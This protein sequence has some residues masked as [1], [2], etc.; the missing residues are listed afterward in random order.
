MSS[1]VEMSSKSM[2]ADR[3]YSMNRKYKYWLVVVTVSTCALIAIIWMLLPTVIALYIHSL[4]SLDLNAV[5]SYFR[6][7]LQ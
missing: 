2:E 6:S 5:S 7:M 4:S 3:E 1:M